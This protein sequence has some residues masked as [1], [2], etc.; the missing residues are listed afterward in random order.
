MVERFILSKRSFYL[1]SFTLKNTAWVKA[2]ILTLS[3]Y[4]LDEKDSSF[5]EFTQQDFRD[6]SKDIFICTQEVN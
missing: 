1:L 3:F 2:W 4:G 6:I 5:Q